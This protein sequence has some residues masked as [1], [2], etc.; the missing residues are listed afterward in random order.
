MFTQTSQKNN[1]FSNGINIY[2]L[3]SSKYNKNLIHENLINNYRYTA[4][5]IDE[6]LYIITVNK[7]PI[8]DKNIYYQKN[9]IEIQIKNDS[10][11]FDNSM[12]LLGH[13][14]KRNYRKKYQKEKKEKKENIKKEKLMKVIIVKVIVE[15]IISI[16][17]I[18]EIEVEVIE[19][20]VEVIKVIEVIVLEVEIIKVEVEVEVI[21]QEVEIIMM[22]TQKY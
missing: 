3:R 17:E 4:N 16:L 14:R 13:K 5:D 1:I 6:D 12:E 8:N 19:V 7:I 18:K 20:K 10:N 15:I 21:V 9:N 22:I 2:S 11:I